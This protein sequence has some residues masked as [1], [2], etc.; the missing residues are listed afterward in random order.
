MLLEICSAT[1]NLADYD[2]EI[3][4]DGVTIR[5]KSGVREHPLLKHRLATQSFV[6]RSLHRL[7]LDIVPARHEI[8]RPAGPHR[9]EVWLVIRRRRASRLSAPYRRHELLTGR[10]QYP[11]QGYTGYGDGVGTDL[12]AFISNEMR[13]DWTANRE[14]LLAFWQ[15]G[16]P[17]NFP[18]SLPWLYVHGSAG[19]LPWAAEHLD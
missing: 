14:E 12:T 3:G 6:V 13:A 7:G 19:S 2:E 18:D 9:G 1:D 17:D 15:S 16:A 11:E 10:I 5:A 8:R 4:R